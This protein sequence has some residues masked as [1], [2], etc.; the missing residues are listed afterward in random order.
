MS[1]KWVWVASQRPSRRT[2]AIVQ[3]PG[4]RNVEPS[5]LTPSESHVVATH[6]VVADDRAAGLRRRAR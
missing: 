1:E 3:R 2:S 4:R 5:G 6:A